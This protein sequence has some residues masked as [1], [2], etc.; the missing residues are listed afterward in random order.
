MKPPFGMIVETDIERYRYS[1][2]ADKEPE[3]VDWIRSFKDGEAFFD[4]G[5]NVGLFSLLCA[6]N[7]P[8][9]QIYA[10]EPMPKN[11]IRLLQN[12]ELN[13]FKNIHCF[14]VAVDHWTHFGNI[15]VPNNEAGQSGTQI[16]KAVDEHNEAFESQA[17]YL[18]LHFSFRD[19]IKGL[20]DMKDYHIKIDVDGH[21]KSVLQ[22]IQKII[23]ARVPKSVLI[24]FNNFKNKGVLDSYSAFFQRAGYTESNIF[25]GHPNHSRI[26]RKKEGIQAEN[27]VFVRE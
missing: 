5:A 19:F 3:T 16:V 6:A 21:E 24:E 18:I 12:V 26:R 14:N 25:N 4:I 20:G 13:G 10:F 9:S 22:G 17:E 7:H 2:W 23:K 11:F 27:I 15:Y 1:T 8:N